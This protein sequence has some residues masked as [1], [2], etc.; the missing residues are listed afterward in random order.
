MLAEDDPNDVLL[1]QFAFREAEIHSPLH[2]VSNGQEAIDYL[3]GVG[4]F[5][6]RERFPIPALL[7]LDLKMPRKTGIDVL[8]WLA[9]DDVMRCLPTVMLSSSTHPGDIEKAYRL[10]V[11]AFVVKS[12]GTAQRTEFCK[13]IKSFWLT[14]N[15]LP[16]VCTDGLEAAR[17]ARIADL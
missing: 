1:L 17:K 4:S 11:N 5:S 2:T 6:D 15:E 3:S 14:L 12:P 16:L 7:L 9:K 8:E 10:G 13:I